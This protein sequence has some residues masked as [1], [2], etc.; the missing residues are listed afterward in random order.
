M[1]GA[2]DTPFNLAKFLSNAGLG[3]TI[4]QFKPKRTLF[5]QGDS[6]DSIFYLQTGKVKLTVVSKSGKEATIAILA[7]GDF[8]GEE[9]HATPGRVHMTTAPQWAPVPL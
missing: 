7:E 6:A 3:R 8:V 9:S 1:I 5:L 4:V 2:S